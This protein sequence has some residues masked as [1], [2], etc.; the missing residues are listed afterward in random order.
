ML[1]MDL[2]GFT[3]NEIFTLPLSKTGKKYY[4]KISQSEQAVK[5]KTADLHFKPT[6]ASLKIIGAK[7][8]IWWKKSLWHPSVRPDLTF[9][10]IWLLLKILAK[11]IWLY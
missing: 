1:L 3:S 5:P 7:T 8:K 11:H 10:P 4:I 9:F 2:Q 6:K